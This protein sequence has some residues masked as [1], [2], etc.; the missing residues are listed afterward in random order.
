MYLPD[1]SIAASGITQHQW[2]QAQVSSVLH[3]VHETA[4]GTGRDCQSNPHDHRWYGRS[5]VQKGDGDTY[6][7]RVRDTAADELMDN[8]F[9][10]CLGTAID[11]YVGFSNVVSIQ[12][13]LFVP[14]DVLNTIG[15]ILKS[16]LTLGR[17]RALQYCDLLSE[18][19]EEEFLGNVHSLAIVRDFKDQ[20]FCF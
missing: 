9:G 11:M 7:Q 18:L 10:H 2:E 17:G 8:V 1:G 4:A 3:C 5:W 13:F 15:L 20:P 12:C 6:M 19:H 14:C 16:P